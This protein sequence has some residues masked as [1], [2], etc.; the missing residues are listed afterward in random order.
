VRAATGSVGALALLGSGALGLQLASGT[1]ANAAASTA[2]ATQAIQQP[3]AA[4]PSTPSVA[5]TQPGN[6]AP[7]TTS[8]GS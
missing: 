7:V 2:A 4:V 5:P 3:P 6:T 1:T 8:G